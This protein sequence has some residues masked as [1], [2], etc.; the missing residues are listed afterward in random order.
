M[1]VLEAVVAAIVALLAVVARHFGHAPWVQQR[2][3]SQQAQA[4]GLG[5]VAEDL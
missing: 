2:L 5:I 4:V 1:A 3:H